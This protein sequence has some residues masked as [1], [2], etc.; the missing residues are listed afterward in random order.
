MGTSPIKGK[1]CKNLKEGDNN[2]QISFSHNTKHR[3]LY[4]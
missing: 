1:F 4:N 3:A 2:K